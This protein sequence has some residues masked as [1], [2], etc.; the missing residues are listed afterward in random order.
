MEQ[1]D[2]NNFMIGNTYIFRNELA[3]ARHTTHV[4]AR[5]LRYHSF[6]EHSTSSGM[7]RFVLHYYLSVYRECSRRLLKLA[8]GSL[9]SSYDWVSKRSKR[10][11]Y[12]LR[13]RYVREN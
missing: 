8:I 2:V 5:L 13:D 6:S 1:N 12:I 10:L 7:S 11:K 9:F 3:D 4:Y